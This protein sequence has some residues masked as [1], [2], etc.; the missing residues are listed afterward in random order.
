MMSGD[1]ISQFRDALR[2]R[3]IIPPAEL[4]GDGRLHRWDLDGPRGKGDAAHLLH[5]DE[6]PAG[7]FQNHKAGLGWERWHVDIGRKLSYSE[8]DAQRTQTQKVQLEPAVDGRRRAEAR[9]RAAGLWR[10]ALPATMEI[11]GTDDDLDKH[12]FRDDVSGH[13]DL[14]WVRE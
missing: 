4:I 14:C 1:P 6:F 8:Q 5:L 7:G 9:E 12:R 11:L 3:N 13:L 10:T 2:R